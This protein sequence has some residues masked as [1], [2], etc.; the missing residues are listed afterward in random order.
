MINLNTKLHTFTSWGVGVLELRADELKT[1]V[2]RVT[3]ETGELVIKAD[4]P[5]IGSNVPGS[6]FQFPF[7]KIHEW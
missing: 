6:C 2:G 7:P 4:V 1:G 3:T 5:V